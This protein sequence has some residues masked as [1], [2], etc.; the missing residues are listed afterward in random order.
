MQ[1][2]R[3]WSARPIRIFHGTPD[4]YNPVGPCK[5]YRERLLAAKVD[6][7]ITEYP[8]APHGFDSPLGFV[9]PRQTASDQ[10]VR[11]CT[12]REGEGGVLVNAATA[13]PFAYTD[14]CVRLRPTV[15]HDAEAT[16]AVTVAVT[17]FLRAVLKP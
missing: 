4:D 15:G 3:P 17:D 1:T 11:D 2:T 9:P 16:V 12:I 14:E 6:I 10:S 13:K 7:S 5:A 8:N